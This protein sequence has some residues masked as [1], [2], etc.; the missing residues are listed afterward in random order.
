MLGYVH[1]HPVIK[2]EDENDTRFDGVSDHNMGSY[3]DAAVKYYESKSSTMTLLFLLLKP[4]LLMLVM[5]LVQTNEKNF[6]IQ[7]MEEVCKIY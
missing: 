2:L 4:L 5:I 3:Y 7:M 1:T 6:A